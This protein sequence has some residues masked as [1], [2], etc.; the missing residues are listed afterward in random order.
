MDIAVAAGTQM[1]QAHIIIQLDD[2]IMFAAVQ[3]GVN[4]DCMS[5]N[6]DM[7]GKF[8]DV[9]THTPCIPGPQFTK[10]ARM[11]AEHCNPQLI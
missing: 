6:A 5:E 3:S 7:A 11:D 8:A 1:D 4:V 10:R 9:N 2:L